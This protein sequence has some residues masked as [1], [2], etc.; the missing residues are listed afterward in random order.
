MTNAPRGAAA[1]KT[2]PNSPSTTA[3]VELQVDRHMTFLSRVAGVG[4]ILHLGPFYD[5]RGHL[6]CSDQRELFV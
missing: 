6:M 4:C 1:G 5:H 3:G 2:T